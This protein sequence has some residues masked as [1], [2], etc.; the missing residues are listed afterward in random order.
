M[1]CLTKLEERAE[2]LSLQVEA[3][4]RNSALDEYQMRTITFLKKRLGEI[5]QEASMGALLQLPERRGEMA[6]IVVETDPDILNPGLGGE[7]IK[8]EAEYY[9]A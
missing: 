3:L 8:I 9:S 6:R 4:L 5:Q 1:S 2:S 7:I